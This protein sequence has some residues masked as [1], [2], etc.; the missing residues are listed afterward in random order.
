MSITELAKERINELNCSLRR[1]K[2]HSEKVDIV[3]AIHHN[4]KIIYGESEIPKWRGLNKAIYLDFEYKETNEAKYKLVCVA[5]TNGVEKQVVWL[6]NSPENRKKLKEFFISKR[7]THVFV[8]W[9]EAEAKCFV[10]LG[11]NPI[12]FHWIDLQ[13]EWKILINQNDD[14][15]YGV[16]LNKE[17][18]E[19]FTT[20]RTYEDDGNL[21]T[22]PSTSLLSATYKLLGNVGPE[23]HKRKK[24]MISLILK[25]SLYDTKHKQDILDYC[26]SDIEDLQKIYEKMWEHFRVLIP[27]H[28]RVNLFQEQLLRGNTSARAAVMS[29]KGYP[30]NREKVTNFTRNIPKIIEDTQLD[31]NEQFPEMD[32]FRKLTKKATTLSLNTKA[33]KAWIEDSDYADKWLK[34]PTKDYSLSLEAFEKFFNWRHDFPRQNFPAQFLRWLKLNQSLNGFKPKSVNAKVKR[35]FFSTYGSDD[36]AHPYL[37][38][39]GSQ[40]GRYQP[41]ASGFLH[42]KAAW[43]RSL[44][45]PRKTKAIGTLDFSSEEF[46]LAALLSKDENMIAAYES[47][48]VYFYF[49]KLA[50]AVPME[51]K[52]KDHE[53]IRDV[54]KSTVLGIS[55]GMGAESLAIKLTNDTGKPHTVE[56][57]EDLIDK[58]E[59]AFPD[60]MDYVWNLKLSY[61]ENAYEE[62]PDSIMKGTSGMRLPDGFWMFGSNHNKKSVAN[63]PIQGFGGMILR[64]A[65]QLAQDCGLD[66]I[67]PLHDALYIEFDS[68]DLGAIDVLE[69]CM[70]E[71]FGYYFKG[72][73]KKKALELIRMDAVIWSPDYEE[74]DFVT[75]NG[76]TGQKYKQ[77]I[78]N[79]S[80]AEYEKFSKYF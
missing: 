14:L 17:G 52:R 72:A 11:L 13:S 42:L 51:A 74:G 38:P 5:M 32:L 68:W 70:R 69:F 10:S 57:A 34:T 8:S 26:Q 47:G 53:D 63:M 73:M 40:S 4:N 46:I 9:G 3:K 76:L 21:H 65:I 37:N 20:R 28:Y 25:S 80:K 56:D 67:I 23:D 49:A 12:H 22:K 36:R 48:D 45:E 7:N 6:Y 71:A 59:K 50:K 15:A 58:F 44:C 61:F 62:D 2:D 43:L 18:R 79:R 29:A 64:K 77:Y 35:T 39:Y 33:V 16:Q 31:I 27:Y 75:P 55:Y 41:Q 60:Y 78:D 66:V 24:E 54:F 30:V 1:N 19:I